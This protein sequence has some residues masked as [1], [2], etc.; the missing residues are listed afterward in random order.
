MSAAEKYITNEHGERELVPKGS[1]L[2]LAWDLIGSVSGPGDLTT[3][4][5]RWKG[6]GR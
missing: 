1:F 2:D 6:F 4:K 5:S 3:N